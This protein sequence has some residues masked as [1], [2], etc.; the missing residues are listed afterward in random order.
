M[1]LYGAKADNLDLVHKLKMINEGTSEARKV[2]KRYG[3]EENAFVSAE[4]YVKIVEDAEKKRRKCEKLQTSEAK[5]K[6]KI[7]VL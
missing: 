2:K 3:V 1:K 7:R 5:Y 6:E 4:D